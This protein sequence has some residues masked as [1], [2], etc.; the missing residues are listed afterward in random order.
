MEVE[1][2]GRRFKVLKDKC[3]CGEKAEIGTGS[4]QDPK[5]CRINHL[6]GALDKESYERIKE[7]I[8]SGGTILRGRGCQSQWA[9]ELR[10]ES[11][12]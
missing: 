1:I 11:R 5:V 4:L 9:L 2:K 8:N 7:F 12:D 10:N 3:W 6:P